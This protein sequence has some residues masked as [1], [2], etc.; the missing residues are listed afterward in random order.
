[1]PH[2]RV[3][4]P[5]GFGDSAGH[6]EVVVLDEHRVVQA[7]TVIGAT[8]ATYGVLF[9]QPQAGGCFAGAN[10]ARGVA[11]HGLH[12]TLGGA[13]DARQASQE[14]ERGAF[15]TQQAAGRTMNDGQ[16]LVGLRPIAVVAIPRDINFGIQ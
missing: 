3:Y 9:Q 2:G 8:P 11:V 15:S 7:E 6:D 13:G 10:D 12:Q 14:I 5:N 4:P 1:M 16:G